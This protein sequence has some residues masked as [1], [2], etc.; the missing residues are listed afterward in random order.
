MTRR[1]SAV[2]LVSFFL[3]ILIGP[4]ELSP[5]VSPTSFERTP[6]HTASASNTGTK[7][8]GSGKAETWNQATAASHDAYL[9]GLVLHSL[10]TLQHGRGG[11]GRPPSLLA[12]RRALFLAQLY[13]LLDKIDRKKAGEFVLNVTEWEGWAAWRAEEVKLLRNVEDLHAAVL[14]IQ[15]NSL[16]HFLTHPHACTFARTR[17]QADRKTDARA[18]ARMNK[19]A[20]AHAHTSAQAHKCAIL[21]YVSVK[22]VLRIGLM[23][24]NSQSS[25]ISSIVMVW[26]AKSVMWFHSRQNFGA[27]LRGPLHSG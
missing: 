8:T 12:T 3:C 17:V 22:Q 26:C 23:Q 11:F 27:S 13:G 25:N 4:A 5:G 20:R 14:C 15:V 19:L 18:Y 2:Q 7:T 9:Q 24:S 21:S 10:H 16:T 1:R 6:S